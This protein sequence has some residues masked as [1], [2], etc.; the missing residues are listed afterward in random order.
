VSDVAARADALARAFAQQAGRAPDGMW[1]APGRVNLLGEHTDYNDGFVLPAAIDREALAAV[2]VRDDDLVTCRSLDLPGEAAVRVGDL[3]PGAAEGWAAYVLGVVWALREA[4]IDV[5][6]LDVL[7][8][9]DVPVGA[10]LSS[11]AALEAA[12]ALAVAELAGA[13][14]SRSEL[15]VACRRAETDVVGAPVGIMD[16]MA[17]LHGRAGAALLLDCRS[18]EVR[19]VELH[20]ADL[21]LQLL[22]VDTRVSHAHASGEYGAR[23][24][25]CEQAAAALG[26]PAL[27]DATLDEVETHLEG[28]QL[29]C[30]RHVVTENARVGQVADALA[31]RDTAALGRLFAA[32]HASMRDDFR[33]SCPEL[34]V[35]VETAVE[36][37]AAAARMTGG[38]FGGC[39]VTLVAPDRVGGV[40]RAV[41][42]AFSARGWPEPR[43]FEVTAAD[44]ARR[45]R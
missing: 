29:R 21:G 20:L 37:G 13:D 4:G 5:P 11:S 34:D 42:E 41:T 27:R 31:A 12:V 14:L 33:I 17:A 32:S 2:G 1:A 15:A 40:E 39:A 28:E 19:P 45:V 18:L 35:T 43:A 24:R 38:G 23:R 26:V 22:V 44:G 8:G 9:S 10:G 3:A 25:A 16:Q 7:V 6:G 30:A 36:A